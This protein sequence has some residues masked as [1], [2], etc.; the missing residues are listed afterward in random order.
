M[1]YKTWTQLVA[2]HLGI[3]VDVSILKANDFLLAQVKVLMRIIEKNSLRVQLTNGERRELAELGAELAPVNRRRYSKIV[4]ADTILSWHRR[5]IGKITKS[6]KGKR[7]GRPPVTDEEKDQVLEMFRKNP[8]WGCMRIAGELK[9]VGYNRCATTVRNIFKKEGIE[10]PPLK[11]RADGRWKRMMDAHSEI[12]QTDFAVHP[13]LNLFSG[14]AT[15]YYIQLFKNI[16]T[17]EVCLG[18]ITANPNAEWMKQSAR[19]I[20]GFELETADLLIRDNDQIYQS[21]FDDIF[22]SSGTSVR[23]TSI[24]SP[25]LNSHIER[26]IR[27]L[28]EECLSQLMIFSKNQLEY[29]VREY[30]QF[31]NKERPHQGL[32]NKI[33]L[34]TNWKVGEGEV[35]CEERL[36]GLLTSFERLSA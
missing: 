34:K 22:E 18:G 9:K 28:K 7:N 33:P 11:C 19:N 2:E 4:Q 15:N 6:E 24:R 12:W 31:Y 14:K 21:N 20:S 17:R 26:F 16:K 13:I 10:P 27:S 23:R 32:G 8:N 3:D 30:L 29:V 36:G 35:V 5:L 25:D 1:K